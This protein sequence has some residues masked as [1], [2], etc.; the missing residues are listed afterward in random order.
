VTDEATPSARPADS[1]APVEAKPGAPTPEE[2]LAETLA[3]D[4]EVGIDG[5]GMGELP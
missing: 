3:E 4:A 2:R 5:T 1:K